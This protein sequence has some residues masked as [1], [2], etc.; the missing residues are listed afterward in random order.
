MIINI[1][2]RRLGN[3]VVEVNAR[4]DSESAGHFSESVDKL[5]NGE[6]ASTSFTF[7]MANLDYVSSLGLRAILMARKKIESAGGKMLMA[8][9]QGPVR[10]VI[11][12]ANVL[13]GWGLFESV[14][15]ADEYFDAMQQQAR[16]ES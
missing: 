16:G 9:L 2:N 5:I 6:P 3:V 11:D 8:N 15:E 10:K 4:L 13:P 12:I 7:D 14:E 1:V